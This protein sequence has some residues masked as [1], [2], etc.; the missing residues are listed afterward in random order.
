M[1]RLDPGRQQ[2]TNYR[3]APEDLAGLS[4][5]FVMTIGEDAAGL[6]W[7]G[8]SGGGLNRLDPATGLLADVGCLDAVQLPFI[9]GSAPTQS[10]PCVRGAGSLP[11][12]VDWFKELFQ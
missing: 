2:F 12:A 5:G 1:S 10:A 7:M 3:P 9:K 8:T 6:L 11:E 4:V